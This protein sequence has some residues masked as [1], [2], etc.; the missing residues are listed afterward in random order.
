MWKDLELGWVVHS[1]MADVVVWVRMSPI[2]S[3]IWTLAT[4]L[5]VLFGENC[6]KLGERRSAGGR[7]SLLGAGCGVCGLP[8]LLPALC[9]L[10][11]SCSGHH[12]CRC[13]ACSPALMDSHASGTINTNKL[14]LPSVAPSHDASSQP[15]KVTNTHTGGPRFNPQGQDKPKQNQ[16]AY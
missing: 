9:S 1:S 8:H 14:F 11:S 7:A 3:G 5:A 2:G 13:L 12:A 10:L 15:Q 4:H 16:G 6:A